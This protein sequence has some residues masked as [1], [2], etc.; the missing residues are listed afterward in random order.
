MNTK[1]VTHLSIITFVLVIISI[2]DL[3]NYHKVVK[4]HEKVTAYK[5]DFILQGFMFYLGGGRKAGGVA[6]SNS[7]ARRK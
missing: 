1:S 7:L 5:E 4:D 3:K 6:E 2:C